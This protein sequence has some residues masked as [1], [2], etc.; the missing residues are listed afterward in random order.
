MN[1]FY[2][3]ICM[4]ATFVLSSTTFVGQS[5][6]GRE[7]LTM[8]PGYANDIFYSFKNGEISTAARDTWDIA[9]YT[10]KFSAGII[11]NEGD[12]VEL[13]TYPKGDT[14]AWASVDTSGMSGWK[15]MYNSPEY[16]EDGAFNVNALGHP[17]Y[18]WGWYNSINHNVY[19]DSLYIIKTASGIKKL[20]IQAKLSVQNI[21]NFKYADLDGN[22]K[23][24]ISLDVTPYETKRFIYYSLE[25]DEAIDREPAKENWDIMF[26]KY[27]DLVSDNEGN[28]VPYLVTGA[29]S[30]V[31]IFSNNFY[32]VGPDYDDYMSKPFDSLKNSIGYDWKSF[33]MGTF[34][35]TVK[36]S[37]YYFV[38]TFDGDV[39]KLQ[40]ISWEGSTT[41]NFEINTTEVGYA[42][43]DETILS[44]SN[45]EV[46]PNPARDHFTLRSDFAGNGLNK[47]IITDEAGKTIFQRDYANTELSK[48]INV[49]NLNLN[50]GLYLII[51]KGNNFTKTQKL[52]IQ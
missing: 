8:G 41:G 17:D 42:A 21:Y 4:I 14:S 35:W 2:T 1:K 48:G 26:T 25:T 50:P 10:P 19:G 32:P 5:N 52:I 37:N 51:I 23:Q 12:G 11:I 49:N 13:Y 18:G 29:T 28:Q 20:I 3:T 40:F 39:F 31:G 27:Y 38:K 6:N 46:Y 45:L 16:W 34:E 43:I 30:N 15:K 47:M 7:A 44:S 9:F 36:D 24:T 33:D 22:N